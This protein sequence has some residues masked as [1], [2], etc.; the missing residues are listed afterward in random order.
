MSLLIKQVVQSAISLRSTFRLTPN[1][2][3]ME[4]EYMLVLEARFYRF[5]S[6]LAHQIY[7]LIVKWLTHMTFYHGVGVRV[8]VGVPQKTTT[9]FLPISLIVVKRKVYIPG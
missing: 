8:S 1:V 7:A 4:L 3:M 5:K 6:C 9:P 2:L